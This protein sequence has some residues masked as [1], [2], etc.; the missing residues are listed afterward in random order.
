MQTLYANITMRHIGD[1]L[2]PLAWFAYLRQECGKAMLWEDGLGKYAFVGAKPI[3]TILKRGNTLIKQDHIQHQNISLVIDPLD[4]AAIQ[5]QIHLW[6]AEYYIE[7]G[8]MDWLSWWG[9]NA[10][11]TLGKEDIYYQLYAYNFVFDYTTGIM[12]GIH[13]HHTPTAMPNDMQ[14]LWTNF[15][16]QDFEPLIIEKAW[17][18]KVND[19]HWQEQ[20]M[21]NEA[22]LQTDYVQ[23]LQTTKIWQT[24]YSGD[25]FQWYRAMRKQPKQNRG[26]YCFFLDAG[27]FQWMGEGGLEP[28]YINATIRALIASRSDHTPSP[29]QIGYP[30]PAAQIYLIEQSKQGYFALDLVKLNIMDSASRRQSIERGFLTLQGHV[31]YAFTQQ[32]MDKN[33]PLSLVEEAH[34]A[35]WQSIEKIMQDIA[36][37]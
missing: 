18:P 9:Y 14:N 5:S 15:R 36:V 8:D 35:Q 33:M 10:I 17:R 34:Q 27:H 32:L 28:L 23:A 3:C 20:L 37:F 21:A 25:I 30:L 12:Q 24:Q 1:L 31:L 19:N 4:S 16:I 29:K 2:S 7:N 6:I 26:K 11:C 22:L 13:L